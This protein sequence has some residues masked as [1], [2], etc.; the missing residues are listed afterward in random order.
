MLAVAFSCTEAQGVAFPRDL[1]SK[2]RRPL[3]NHFFQRSPQNTARKNDQLAAA[4]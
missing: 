2:I 1:W 4:T 3:T